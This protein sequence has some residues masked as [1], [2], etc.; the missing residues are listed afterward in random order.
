MATTSVGSHFFQESGLSP[1]YA[2]RGFGPHTPL[3]GFVTALM[4]EQPLYLFGFF[5]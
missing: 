1:R 5:R 4:Q 3:Q 2:V